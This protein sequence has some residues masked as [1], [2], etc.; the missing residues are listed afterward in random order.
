MALASC[1]DLGDPLSPSP[2]P[3]PEDPQRPALTGVVPLRTYVGDRVTLTGARFGG[4]AAAGDV[5]FA[6]SA[7]DVTADVVSWSDDEIVAEV[8]AGAVS[9]L[10]RVRVGAEVSP[11]VSFEVAPEVSYSS[12]LVPLFTTYG[13]VSCHGGI[14]NLNVTPYGSLLAGTSDNG[15]VVVPG[16]AMAS[17]LWR[18]VNPTPPV[19][20]RMP[21]G[22]PYLQAAEVQRIADWID[23]GAR[24]N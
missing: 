19:G 21:Q 22:G 9:G 20:E 7:G 24:D 14:N 23:Q 11:G 17:L 3:P 15:P 6:G 16:D 8:P 12:D 18:K 4:D 1:T 2:P 13:C 5:A 10:V